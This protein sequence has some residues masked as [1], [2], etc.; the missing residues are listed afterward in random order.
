MVLGMV[1][2]PLNE[3]PRLYAE[4]SSKLTYRGWV[5]TVT[6]LDAVDGVFRHAALVGKLSERKHMLLP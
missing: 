5:C 4:R 1:T 2:T 6:T 3:F